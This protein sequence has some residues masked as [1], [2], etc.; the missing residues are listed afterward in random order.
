MSKDVE[1]TQGN[2]IV[3]ICGK[4]GKRK[5]STINASPSL[6]D[7]SFKGQCKAK[8]IIDKFKKTGQV[9][10]LAKKPGSYQDTSTMPDLHQAMIQVESAKNEFMQI[11]ANIRKLF[12]NSMVKYNEFMLDPKNYPRS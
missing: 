8:N 11:P 9:S 3:R 12:D 4:T 5:V 10:H 7:Q 1:Y 6:T 2:K